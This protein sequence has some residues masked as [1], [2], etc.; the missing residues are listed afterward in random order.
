MFEENFLQTFFL[1]QEITDFGITGNLSGYPSGYP[2]SRLEN[3]EN[4]Y[5]D[6][7]ATR[8]TEVSLRHIDNLKNIKNAF[9]PKSNLAGLSQNAI[10]NDFDN[11]APFLNRCLNF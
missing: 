1:F 8:L 9:I 4:F 11:D 3:L 5:L 6:V 10:Y 2:L 7:K